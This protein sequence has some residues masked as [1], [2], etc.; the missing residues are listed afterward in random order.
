MTTANVSLSFAKLTGSEKQ[1]RWAESI[2]MWLAFTQWTLAMGDLEFVETGKWNGSE[3]T[4]NPEEGCSAAETA[5]MQ[6]IA[7]DLAERRLDA[8][9]GYAGET[10]AKKLIDLVTGR[11]SFRVCYEIARK[12]GRV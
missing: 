11:G 8:A 12:E 3:S 6:E 5:E 7:R 1:V 4:I 10:S 2:R 9:I